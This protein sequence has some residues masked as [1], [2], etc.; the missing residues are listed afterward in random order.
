MEILLD[1]TQSPE[2]RLTGTASLSG[3]A[4]RLPFSGTLELMAR[5]EQLCRRDRAVTPPGGAKTPGGESGP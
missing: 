5:V 4:D 2:G 1:V 3:G